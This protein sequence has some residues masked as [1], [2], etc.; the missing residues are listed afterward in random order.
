MSQL[1][2]YFPFRNQILLFCLFFTEPKKQCVFHINRRK[3]TN[4]FL[5][6]VPYSQRLLEDTKI[7]ILA[8][9]S[10]KIKKK[11]N[12]QP[13][14]EN[15]RYLVNLLT[16]SAGEFFSPFMTKKS[17]FTME[18][19]VQQKMNSRRLE[20]KINLS[21]RTIRSERLIL[22]QTLSITTKYFCP[23]VRKFLG[24][25]AKAIFAVFNFL[26]FILS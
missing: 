23:V 5:F 14:G 21:V 22:F 7:F 19:S 4:L 18:V 8:F 20:N 15:S 9:T 25:I 1:E 6:S 12:K 17:S 24:Q 26:I 10:R 2:E 13:E 11:L 3:K 16:D